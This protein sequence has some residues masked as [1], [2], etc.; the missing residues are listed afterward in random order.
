MSPTIR[1]ASEND[2][3]AIVSI[4]NSTIPGRMVTAD[5]TPV[6]V[7]SRLAWFQEHTPRVRPLWVVEEVHTVVAWL[8]FSSFYGRPAYDKT[9]EISI[10]VHEVWRGK[11][12]GSALLQAAIAHSPEIGVDTLLGFI[13]GHNTPS[14]NLFKKFGFEQWGW[15]PQV[16]LLDEVERDVAILG[17][18]TAA[19]NRKNRS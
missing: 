4:Y 17:K 12:L 10:Y 7:E 2:L 11:G 13:F 14:L 18:K 5:T 1:T 16:A 3:P 8:S 9:A 15:L 19:G 6:S